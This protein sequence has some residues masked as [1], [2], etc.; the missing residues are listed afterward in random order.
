MFTTFPGRT[1][2]DQAQF[3]LVLRLSEQAISGTEHH[4]VDQ[5]YLSRFI[6]IP[7][8]D[9]LVAP[10]GADMDLRAAW[11]AGRALEARNQEQRPT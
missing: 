2:F 4:Q 8:D 11:R 9:A 6:A 10:H 5:R 1:R 3:D 7:P